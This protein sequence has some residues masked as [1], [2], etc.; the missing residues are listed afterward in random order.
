[1]SRKA[2]IIMAKQPYPGRSKTR[3]MP[4]LSAEDAAAI[5]ACFLQDIVQLVQSM[6]DVRPFIAYAPDDE[7]TRQ[8]MDRLAPAISSIPQKGETLGDRLDFVLRICQE[9]GF[10]QVAAMNSDSPNL[11]RSFLHQAF[12][13]LDDPQVDVVL[14]P[15]EDGGY[16]LIGWKRPHPRLVREVEMSTENVL[17]DTLAIAD[18]EGLRVALLPTWY[19]VD[20][21]DD[22][23]RLR[24]QL[25]REPGMA[26]HTKTFLRQINIG[27]DSSENNG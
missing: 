19:D 12:A 25:D 13:R 21:S 1:M 5:Y 10:D 15:C 3:L 6:A 11:P 20:E 24:A 17:Q 26:R 14:G 7:P 9:Q 8:Y 22:L 2:L 4:A 16:Y 27:Q 18:E 23:L